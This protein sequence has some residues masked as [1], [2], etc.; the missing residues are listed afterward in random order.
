M[1][2][3]AR[4]LS[5]PLTVGAAGEGAE[6]GAGAR[7]CGEAAAGAAVAGRRAGAAG[8]AA[9]GG[10]NGALPGAA[11]GPPGGNVGNLMVG[12]AEGFGG[13]LMRTV[14]FLGW[15]LDSGGLGGTPPGRL[16]ILSAICFVKSYLSQV[17]VDPRR[18]QTLIQR[19]FKVGALPAGHARTSG[20]RRTACPARIPLFICILPGAHWS[21]APPRPSS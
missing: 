9:G 8:A 18:C 3:I 16:G 2:T 6:R 21:G 7:C 19:H 10:A 14:S 17:R 13:K 15:T 1:A 20:G 5:K 12:A 4:A 11:E